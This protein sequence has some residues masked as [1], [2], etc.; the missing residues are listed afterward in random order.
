MKI[1]NS[2]SPLIVS[3]GFDPN[4]SIMG[5]SQEAALQM[6]KH[7]RDTIYTNKALAV[8]REFTSN[9]L[10]EHLKF[11]IAD[12]VKIGL[13]EMDNQR[14]FFVRDFAKGLSEKEIRTVFGMYGNS[15]KL[16]DNKTVGAY[17]VGSK[18][19]FCYTDSYYVISYFGGEKTIY[20]CAL[21]G[22]NKGSSNGFIYKTHSEPSNETGLE[23]VVPIQ[24]LDSNKFSNEI[25]SFVY[26]SPHNIEANVLGDEIKPYP[27]AKK[28]VINNVEFTLFGGIFGRDKNNQAVL[29]MGGVKYESFSIPD[30]FL[31]KNDHTL[32][33]NV[34]IGAM[35][36]AL[37]RESFHDT[38]LNQNYKSKIHNILEE[39][40]QKD[41]AHIKSKPLKDVI[42]ENLGEI[43]FHKWCDGSMF[44]AKLA[45][46][47]KET[48]GFVGGITVSNFKEDKKHNFVLKN[49]KPILVLIP[50]NSATDYWR[51]K[52]RTFAIQNN[53][54]YYIGCQSKF[55]KLSPEAATEIDGIFQTMTVKRIPFPKGKR[56]K[57]YAVY[58]KDRKKGSFN[59]VGFLNLVR[60][61]R[62][63]L[64]AEPDLTKLI[65]WVKEE[66]KKVIQMEKNSLL[67]S[68]AQQLLEIMMQL[69]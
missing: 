64:P 57:T 19:G 53:E 48:W 26:F 29:Q 13:R 66:K 4:A 20:T 30:G 45:S 49:D 7:L 56:E 61:E 40:T 16:N 35:T 38:P 50:D 3:D 68:L 36:V 21:G 33:I 69:M 28:E 34:P 41:F 24:H 15:T 63:S 6:A 55:S 62:F 5:M 47:F 27:I 58:C 1:A 11:N 59:A 8:V 42:D 32:A 52:L 25:R 44:Q 22:D 43:S 31:V 12:P 23:V 60:E 10:D 14:E 39:L 54:S 46:I 2:A 9:G 17:G 37:S 18:S 51:S 65:E 67:I